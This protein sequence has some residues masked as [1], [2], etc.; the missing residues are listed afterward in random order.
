MALSLLT[1]REHSSTADFRM[2]STVTT[3]R[4]ASN[5][6]TGPGVPSIG[7]NGTDV[8]YDAAN[9]Y[10][11][12]AS[13]AN[14]SILVVNGSTRFLAGPPIVVGPITSPSLMTIDTETNSLYVVTTA[15]GSWAGVSVVNLTTSRLLVTHILV[16]AEP[17]G[18]AF[19][20]Q[21]EMIYVSN[22]ATNNVSVI[23]GSS[24]QLS[25]SAISISLPGALAFDPR[26]GDLYVGEG[27][28]NGGGGVINT[29]TNLAI[30]N[31]TGAYGMLD[32]AY[33]PANS[34]LYGDSLSGQA[35]YVIND[36]PMNVSATIRD[37]GSG[38]DGI[39]VEANRG[40]VIFGDQ[41]FDVATGTFH[42]PFLPFNVEQ[43]AEDPTTGWLFAPSTVTS[44]EGPILAVHDT[45]P[46]PL[47]FV[48][49]GLPMG[50]LWSV[51]LP[52]SFYWDQT[53]NPDYI[54]IVGNHSTNRTLDLAEW[55]GTYA[56]TVTNA[57]GPPAPPPGMVTVNGFGAVTAV[58]FGPF[59]YG[60]TLVASGLPDGSPWN[61]TVTGGPGLGASVGGSSTGPTASL[62][63][64]NGSYSVAA[65]A[66]DGFRLPSGSEKLVVNGSAVNQTLF[67]FPAPKSPPALA[68]PSIADVALVIGVAGLT[69]GAAALVLLYRSRRPPVAA[70]PPAP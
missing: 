56:Y 12:I 50:T 23:N 34:N 69:V 36:T 26:T 47:E 59:Q 48:E 22:T 63:L 52:E 5:G 43:G 57:G 45:D 11:Y 28:S 27:T 40:R 67:F 17:G 37:R 2:G 44:P 31:R 70:P 46:V 10:L 51:F 9:G 49:T 39:V 14:D 25:G 8:D 21:N 68:L 16:G 24:N 29:T 41:V 4:P 13:P 6:S 38:P 35:V 62:Q 58:L 42:E 3:A 54:T 33:D 19:D 61:W 66:S 20:P 18:I 55:Y 65:S 7:V 1:S 15:V 64:G 53:A 32:V 60:V 30:A